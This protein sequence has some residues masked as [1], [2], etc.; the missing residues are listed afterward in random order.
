MDDRIEKLV[1][2][3]VEQGLESRQQLNELLEHFK[4]VPQFGGEIRAVVQPQQPDVNAVRA[5]KVQ[6]LTLN[7]TK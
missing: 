4:K 7:L 2:D 6:R 5:E 3:A 1:H